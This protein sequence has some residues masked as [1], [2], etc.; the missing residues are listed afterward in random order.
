MNKYERIYLY[1][2]VFRVPVALFWSPGL[3]FRMSRFIFWMSGLAWKTCKYPTACGKPATVHWHS[4]RLV[5]VRLKLCDLSVVFFAVRGVV[6]TRGFVQFS[7]NFCVILMLFWSNVGV[8]FVFFLLAVFSSKVAPKLVQSFYNFWVQF[9][10]PF[11]G[12]WSSLGVFWEPSWAS[13][14]SFGR[15]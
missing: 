1:L 3:V 11:L 15:P 13:W 9:R 7:C 6:F 8:I 4:E 12:S 14:L 10:V 5:D 2:H